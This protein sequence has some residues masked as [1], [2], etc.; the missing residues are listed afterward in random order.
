M[1]AGFGGGPLGYALPDDRAGRDRGP[2]R[3]VRISR[4]ELLRPHFG[5]R[6]PAASERSSL[7][8]AGE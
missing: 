5:G 2:E 6:V 4:D 7:R 3:Q 8:L 1:I